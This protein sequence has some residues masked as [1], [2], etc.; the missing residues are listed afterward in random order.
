MALTWRHNSL[1][2]RHRELGSTLEP[3]NGMPTAWTYDR[4]INDGYTAI[5]TK[6]GLM[7][8]SGLNVV[9]VVGPH[10]H[11]VLNRT[12]TRDAEKLKAG[13]ATYTTILDDRGM[14]VDDGILYRT[15]ISSFMMV[16]GSGRTLEQLNKEAVGR[17]VAVLFDSDMHILSLQGPNS[18]DFLSKHVPAVKDLG[19]FAHFDTTL[20]GCLVKISR[21]GYTG[22]EY[23]YE[24]YCH[25]Q[26]APTL[27]DTI[28]EEGSYAGIIPVQFDALDMF[29]VEAG[30]LFFPDDNSEA[31]PFEDDLPGDTLWE[32]GLDFTVSASNDTFRG[33][34]QHEF[35]KGRERFRIFGIEIDSGDAVKAGDKVLDESGGEIG[36]VTCAMRSPLS[37]RSKALVR[38][39]PEFASPDKKI[40]VQTD[41][42][43]KEGTTKSLP[44]MD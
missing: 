15:G 32:L 11:W 1:A 28:L 23:G 26:D 43:S 33:I 2:D 30:L 36:V 6:A 14:L 38:V 29:R 10:A 9:H 20:F 39:T 44:M 21:T 4:D 25:S 37:K 35:R 22:E 3:W 12:V 19:R 8:I 5:R 27:W 16:H 7:D 40:Q 24:I 18:V 31:H 34:A 41:G 13:R 42:G 17:E